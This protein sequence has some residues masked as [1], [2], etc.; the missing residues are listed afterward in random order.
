[1]LIDLPEALVDVVAQTRP[2]FLLKSCATHVSISPVAVV[3]LL[4]NRNR[5]TNT[6]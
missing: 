6:S 5:H 4:I 3:T 2:P 1:L